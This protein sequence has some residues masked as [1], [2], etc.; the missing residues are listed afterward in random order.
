TQNDSPETFDKVILASHADQSLALL[1]DADAQEKNLLSP[2]QYQR[3]L[4]TL[5]TD[6]SVMPKTKLAWSSW[7]YRI[8]QKP[9]SAVSPSTIYW[10]N[11]LQGVSDR[12]NYFVSIN[13][14]D[15]INPTKILKRIEYHHPLFNLDAIRA[16]E[17]LPELNRRANNPIYFCGSYF[18]YGFHEDAF[19]SA[20][21][22]C[23]DLTGE[24]I[25][26]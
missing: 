12:E 10:M 15:K 5:H 11:S 7:N 6:A 4:A 26:N 2:F 21:N 3:N 13:G 25:W 17:Q 22:L 18:K 1:A 14:E 16:Q 20:L 9:D 8:D 24:K 19:T 23:R